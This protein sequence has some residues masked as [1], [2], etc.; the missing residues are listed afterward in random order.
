MV[1]AYSCSAALVVDW[2]AS[3]GLPAD[4]LEIVVVEVV[5]EELYIYSI[6]IYL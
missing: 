1:A 5:D 3:T 6:H 2:K 4:Y